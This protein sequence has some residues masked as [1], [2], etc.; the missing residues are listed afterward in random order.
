TRAVEEKRKLPELTA[1]LG[2]ELDVLAE[3]T[4]ETASLSSDVLAH[5]LDRAQ[6]EV[7]TDPKGAS[8]LA[9]RLLA[10]LEGSDRGA[11]ARDVRTKALD[12]A[13]AKDP[14]D[15]DSLVARAALE[16]AEGDFVAARARLE[17]VA[18]KLG[19]GEGA[20]VLGLARLKGGA[21]DEA[22]AYLSSYY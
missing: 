16:Y 14:K 4:A 20:R 5:A 8:E 17:P 1:V 22:V 2:A 21:V 18:D 6:A 3:T 7:A 13:I 9:A 10:V 19:T 11:R 15:A 12:A